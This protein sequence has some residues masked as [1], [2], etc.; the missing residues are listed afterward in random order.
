MGCKQSDYFALY[1]I[2][3]PKGDKCLSFV[4]EYDK[5]SNLKN[6]RFYL[7]GF[8]PINVKT[9]P[10]TNYAILS[11]YSNDLSFIT[12]RWDLDTIIIRDCKII[13]DSLSPSCII[14]LKYKRTEKEDREIKSNFNKLW[15]EYQLKGIHREEY[16]SCK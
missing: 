2:S 9:F 4:G 11:F 7:L 3:S 13:T 5:W 14:D 1:T 10:T 15:F 8:N 16:K 6:K 12:V